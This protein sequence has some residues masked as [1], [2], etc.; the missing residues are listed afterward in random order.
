MSFKY[1]QF[2]STGAFEITDPKTPYPWINYLTNGDYCALTSHHGGGFSFYKDPAR[3]GTLRREMDGIRRDCPGRF[4]YVV[5]EEQQYAWSPNRVPTNVPL[6][7]FRCVHEPG[8]T[9]IT[10]T[11][12]DISVELTY[13]V[14][15]EEQHE[16]WLVRVENLGKK[17]R[18][19]RV[20]SLSEWLMGNTRR[21][22]LDRQWDL[23]MKQV[24]YD[25]STDSIVGRK[26]HWETQTDSPREIQPWP[27]VQYMTSSRTPDS[28][29]TDRNNFFGTYR[30]YHNPEALE[31]ANLDCNSVEGADA[32][33]AFDWHFS[34]AG[35][36]VE[37]WSCV[38]G[39]VPSEKEEK[40]PWTAFQDDDYATNALEATREFWNERLGSVNV[41]LPDSNLEHLVNTWLPYQVTINCWFG[42]A[43][44]FWHSSQGYT[45]F[46]D[47]CHEAFGISPVD[48]EDARDNLEH[49]LSFTFENGLNSHRTPRGARD[50]D[51]SDNADDPLWVPFAL[52]A[53][54]RETGDDDILEE[55]IGYL[56]SDDTSSVLEHMIEGVD[57]VLTQ[58]GERGLPLI[59]YGDW[60]DALDTLG[61]EGEGESVWIGQ[62]LVL[63]LRKAAA[64]CERAG[65]DETAQRYREE[66]QKTS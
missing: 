27:Y 23:L 28:W 26:R 48:P 13:F 3:H 57:Y 55:Q 7:D 18:R 56:E 14:P 54:L 41:E 25:Q 52:D 61:E 6:D 19:I 64:I 50:Y 42:R 22:A 60:N 20:V 1:G 40:S 34:L 45:G 35:E 31:Y 46:R 43:P 24:D 8:V 5:D 32:I 51:E 49:I 17:A 66:A 37:D 59:R 44:S 11:Y 39:I 62:F 36:S 15:P 29:E 4:F 63:S 2:L 53:Y 58:R 47:A 9:T 10:S 38:L 33:G 16:V 30:G 12:D 65:R 21:D